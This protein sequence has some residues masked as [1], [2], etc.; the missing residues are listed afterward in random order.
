MSTAMPL[1]QEKKRNNLTPSP[2]LKKACLAADRE[3]GK[4][5]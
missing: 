4:K 5:G 1:T 3:R 2:L